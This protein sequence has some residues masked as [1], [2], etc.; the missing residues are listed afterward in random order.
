MSATT[1][2]KSQLQQHGEYERIFAAMRRIR[3]DGIGVAFHETVFR[4]ASPKYADLPDLISGAGSKQ[5][6]SRWNP[7]GLMAVLH[8]AWTP[9][10]AVSEAMATRRRYNLPDQA[11]LPLMIRGIRCKLRGV[12]DLRDG[13]VRVSIRVSLE[14]ML[15]T[16]WEH[17]NNQGAEALTQAIGRAAASAGFE[18]LLV[19][20]VAASSGTNTVVFVERLGRR[21]RIVLD[22][23][24]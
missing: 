18:G 10:D 22:E 14:R 17:E 3:R 23:A 5:N 1:M 11:S 6:G 4:A 2:N 24:E 16:D 7:P 9:E 12:L 8:A 19:P 15:E 21:S 20:S 13:D